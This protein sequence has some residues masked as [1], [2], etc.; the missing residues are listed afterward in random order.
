MNISKLMSDNKPTKKTKGEINSL[1]K[2][3]VDD[4]RKLIDSGYNLIQVTSFLNANDVHLSK[5][6][7]VLSM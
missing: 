4:I 7:V 6:E 5:A 2:P 3:F 1:P